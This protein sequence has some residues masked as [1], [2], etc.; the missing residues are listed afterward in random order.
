MD[1][2]TNVCCWHCP[3]VLGQI[4]LIL[5]IAA[6]GIFLGR[7]STLRRG[8]LGTALLT[9]GVLFGLVGLFAIFRDGISWSVERTNVTEAA[10]VRVRSYDYFAMVGWVAAMA[11]AWAGASRVGRRAVPIG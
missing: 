8:R 1:F 5:G 11:T 6:L 2:S 3:I 10:F 7:L 4:G 9:I